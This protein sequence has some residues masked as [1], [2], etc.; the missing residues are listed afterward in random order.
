MITRKNIKKYILTLII[1]GNSV[2][3]FSQISESIIGTLSDSIKSWDLLLNGQ[4]SYTIQ[5]GEFFYYYPNYETALATNRE[6]GKIP[7]K[8]VTKIDSLKYLRFEFTERDIGF[9]DY[10][11]DLLLAKRK[12]I[13]YKKL[14]Q[15]AINHD[16]EALKEILGLE[17]YV[18]GA[19]T[20]M[21]ADRFWRIFHFWSDDELSEL[22]KND[23]S[24]FKTSFSNF[25][26]NE[27]YTGFTIKEIEEYI[28]LF[29]PKTLEL[30]K[31]DKT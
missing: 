15:K 13:N 30:I 21:F 20:E 25:L 5:S 26:L 22:L 4:T 2:G 19:A 10:H 27:F 31:I 9:E 28:S 29:F 17:P 18:D 3:L 16:G 1:L 11:E 23:T 14:V 7:F 24:G 6:S 12:G 8:Y